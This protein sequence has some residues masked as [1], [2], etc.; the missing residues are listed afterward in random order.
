MTRSCSIRLALE[1]KNQDLIVLA[2][3]VLPLVEICRDH[4]D[5]PAAMLAKGEAAGA[6]RHLAL[7]HE[8]NQVSRN[9]PCCCSSLAAYRKY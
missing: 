5:G 8:E 6:L 9:N 2:G 7:E 3:A 1:E 4:D